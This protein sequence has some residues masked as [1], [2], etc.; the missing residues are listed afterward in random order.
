M[1]VLAKEFPDLQAAIWDKYEAG[2]V[3]DLS[4]WHRVLNLYEF[5][6]INATP[7]GLKPPGGGNDGDEYTQGMVDL[8]KWYF[9]EEVEKADVR[10]NYHQC[11]GIPVGKWML[12][13]E[14]YARK[15]AWDTQRL[16]FA[17]IERTGSP[18][19]AQIDE[20]MTNICRCGT[21]P[22]IRKAILA[23][24]GQAA[25]SLQGDA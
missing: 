12:G 17:L 13:F 7:E 14:E 24:T 18:S 6:I 23:A 11:Y 19:D 1:I 15:D 9:D 25:A 5:G 16:L 22:R 4:T 8:L 21:Y 20:A 10:Y 3:V 2:Q